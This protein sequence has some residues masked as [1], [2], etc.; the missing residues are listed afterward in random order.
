MTIA[1]YG[2]TGRTARA[3]IERLRGVA[4]LRLCGRDRAALEALAA[5]CGGA[6]ESRV[7]P[8]D[9][10][11]P[12]RQAFHGV[13]TVIQCAALAARHAQNVATAALEQGAAYLDVCADESITE[14]VRTECDRLA[15]HRGAS[16]CPGVA[17]I[18]GG[19]AEW[20]AIAAMRALGREHIAPDS[21]SLGYCASGLPW[22]AGSL[23]SAARM[24]S[25]QGPWRT[26]AFEFPPPFGREQAFAFP[27][28]TGRLRQY[29]P[30]AEIESWASLA[31]SVVN[32][33][34]AANILGI[35]ASTVRSLGPEAWEPALQALLPAVSRWGRTMTTAI[36]FAVVATVRYGD[37]EQRMAAVADA[38]YDLTAEMLGLV[39]DGLAEGPAG[40]RGVAEL[41]RAEHALTSLAQR[42]VLQLHAC[43]CIHD[44]AQ[45]LHA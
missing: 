13:D 10:I 27:L 31:P 20:L 15:R 7:A 14:A 3:L 25:R 37:V 2:A 21:I 8:A 12:L 1:I 38:P 44:D 9:T 32:S 45:E 29:F 24:L 28:G 39:V 30:H 42:G 18:G 35:L 43:P 16:L 5:A 11:E 19:L 34:R 17:P 4:A 33:Q 40:A 36:R 26:Q 6:T 41:V 23:A 22:S